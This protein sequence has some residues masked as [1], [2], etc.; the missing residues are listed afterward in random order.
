M[1][2]IL[3]TLRTLYA[4]AFTTQFRGYFKG[5]QKISA[6]DDL[7]VLMVYGLAT[8][9]ERSGTVRDKAEY[10]IAVEVRLSV[11]QYFDNTNGQGTQLDALDALTNLVENRNSGGDL[12]TPTV[13]G[14]LNDNLT[15]GGLVLYTNS[16]EVR[17][18]E[19]L[20]ANSFPA[21]KAIVTFTAYDRPNR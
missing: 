3:D 8:R 4:T 20:E 13:M 18:E 6:V 1:N 14:V 2:E 7:P 17:Y 5:K 21:V 12:E 11:K 19:Y 15:I 16:M 9:Q 10:D